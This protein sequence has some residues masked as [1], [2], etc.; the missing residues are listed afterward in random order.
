M[1]GKI[2]TVGLNRPHWRVYTELQGPI[3]GVYMNYIAPKERFMWGCVGPWRNSCGATQGC[4][5]VCAGHVEV[6]MGYRGGCIRPISGV[7]WLFLCLRR[8]KEDL[9]RAMW[10]VYGSFW[11]GYVGALR[12]Y[13]MA[14][15]GAVEYLHRAKEDDTDTQRKRIG[16]EKGYRGDA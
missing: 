6:Y 2:R 11:E 12:V 7:R 15:E 13:G 9:H 1:V 14:C 4:I 8:A 16:T 5:G 3:E 10:P